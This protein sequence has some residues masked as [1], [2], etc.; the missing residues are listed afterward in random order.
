MYQPPE[1]ESNRP[2]F[3]DLFESN[4]AVCYEVLLYLS[5]RLMRLPPGAPFTFV[6]A[7]PNAAEAIPPWCDLRGFSLLSAQ[8]ESDGRWKFELCR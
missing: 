1:P 4:L 7:D 6:T 5:S 8:R 2:Q 3:V